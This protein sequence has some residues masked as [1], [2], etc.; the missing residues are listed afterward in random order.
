VKTLGSVASVVAAI[1]DDVDAEVEAIRGRTGSA[2]AAAAA[3]EA[4]EPEA[5]AEREAALVVARQKARER[6][7]RADWQGAREA[8]TERERWMTAVAEE[9]LRRLGLPPADPATRRRELLALL[10]DAVEALPGEA[11][12]AAMSPADAALFATDATAV[13][14]ADVRVVADETVR[15]GCRVFARGGRASFDNT[16]EARARRLEPEWRAALGQLYGP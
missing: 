14:G 6:M 1:A 3:E 5:P 7:A 13:T 12:E 2:R 16:F 15:G 4:A 10:H 8:L 11:F 9:G